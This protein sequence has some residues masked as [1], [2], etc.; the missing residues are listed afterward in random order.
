MGDKLI[1]GLFTKAR[2]TTRRR[3]GA[4]AGDVGRL[5]RLFHGTI[6]ALAA[7]QESGQDAFEAVDEAV[8]WPKLLRVRGEVETLADL[9]GVD[10]L[11]RAA[12]RWKTLRKFA[13]AL[14]EALEFHA[15]RGGSDPMLAALRLLADLNRSGKRQVPPDAPMPFR[16]EWRRLVLEEGKPNRRLY[17]TAVLATLRDRLRSGDVW[18][19]RSAGYRRFDAYLLPQAAVPTAAAALGLPPTADEWLAAKGRELDRRLKRFAGRLKRGELEG[20]ELRDGRLHVAPVKASAPPEAKAF[21]DRLDTM[22]PPARI[23]ELLH[24]VARATGFVRARAC[25]G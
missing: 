24:E 4:S 20:V 10:P 14:I 7:T 11:V 17:E 12:D 25:R 13:P 6:G 2:N 5:M 3:I 1:G 16:K 22:L 9:A 23:T 18:V 8:G 21:A 19:E 15:A